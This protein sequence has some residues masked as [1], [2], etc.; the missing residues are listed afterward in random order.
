M[1]DT[2]AAATAAEVDDGNG[3]PLETRAPLGPAKLFVFFECAVV[4]SGDA[5]D[6]A[7]ETRLLCLERD[8]SPF[9]LE[10]GAFFRAI[11]RDVI[12]SSG[13][14]VVRLRALSQRRGG[15]VGHGE[16]AGSRGSQPR[17]SFVRDLDRAG[18]QGTSSPK[19][20]PK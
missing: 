19:A 20:A 3:I 5:P 4:N 16:Q 1:S 17:K 7:A 8:T 18:E 10:G 14:G 6:C 9:F 15:G 12:P 13:A 2:T 11:S